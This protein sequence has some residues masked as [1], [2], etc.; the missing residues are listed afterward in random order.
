MIQDGDKMIAKCQVE[1]AIEFYNRAMHYI[2]TNLGGLHE[3]LGLI[4]KKIS[5]IYFRI[6]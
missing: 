1:E 5:N 6:G 4:H 2:I 3:K